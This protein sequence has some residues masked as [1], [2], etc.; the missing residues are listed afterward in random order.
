MSIKTYRIIGATLA[1]PGVPGEWHDG[2]E[3]DVDTDTN[4]VVATR[5]LPIVAPN[6]ADAVPEYTTQPLD[7]PL[8]HPSALSVED[9][10][11]EGV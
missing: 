9:K 2:Q 1:I 4:T 3:V 8:E 6:S 7:E 5:L 10:A 11:V